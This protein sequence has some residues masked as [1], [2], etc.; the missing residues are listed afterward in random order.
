MAI[1]FVA[2]DGTFDPMFFNLKTCVSRLRKC[3]DD[4]FHWLRANSCLVSWLGC[5]IIIC[6]VDFLQRSLSY[7]EFLLLYMCV[8]WEWI[9]SYLIFLMTWPS[10]VSISFLVGKICGNYLIFVRREIDTYFNMIYHIL[11]WGSFNILH[12]PP[13]L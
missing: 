10:F 5:A 4:M 9:L 12:I 8:P 2:S 7:S 13:S 6:I 1:C 11:H 3:Y